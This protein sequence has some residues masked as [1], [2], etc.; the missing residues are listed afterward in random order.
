MPTPTRRPRPRPPCVHPLLQWPAVYRPAG[1]EGTTRVFDGPSAR[2]GESIESS[3]GA[4]ARAALSNKA[5]N[6]Q[7][8]PTSRGQGA[9]GCQWGW[10]APRGAPVR[11]RVNQT[12]Q[13]RGSGK[14]WPWPKRQRL[15]STGGV[16]APP[17][18]RGGAVCGFG[19]RAALV[20]SSALGG[21]PRL[22]DCD[23]R[24]RGGRLHDGGR[25]VLLAGAAGR[26]RDLLCGGQGVKDDL[27]QLLLAGGS[28]GDRL[29]FVWGGGSEGEVQVSKVSSYQSGPAA[30]KESSSGRRRC[31][32]RGVSG[33]PPQRPT[34]PH[35]DPKERPARPAP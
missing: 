32:P 17:G 15:G 14:M 34:P 31:S 1:A 27:D 28:K 4:S 16:N 19:Q 30:S 13:G 3:G 6:V 9:R 29:L 33:R 22:R 8:T 20:G 26:R 18:G 12:V 35:P 11:C 2:C 24:R 21:A 7:R 25:A 10:A 23:G 5:R